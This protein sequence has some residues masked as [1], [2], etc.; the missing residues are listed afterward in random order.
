MR[1][2]L[3][4]AGHTGKIKGLFLNREMNLRLHLAPGYLS[5]FRA[6]DPAICNS[7]YEL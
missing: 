6:L 4:I 7:L 3:P 1:E 5:S 2:L